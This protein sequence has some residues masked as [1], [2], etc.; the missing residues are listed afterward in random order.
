MVDQT[1]IALI[2]T[3][4]VMLALLGILPQGTFSNDEE[5]LTQTFYIRHEPGLEAG[6][7]S[8]S[9][10]AGMPGIYEIKTG[11]ALWYVSLAAMIA[12]VVLEG[13]RAAWPLPVARTA[14]AIVGPV[15]GAAALGL[16][17]SGAQAYA[18]AAD[19]MDW[20]PAEA[21]MYA[22]IAA[23]VSAFGAWIVPWVRAR[24]QARATATT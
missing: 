11:V 7:W 12:W 14:A 8:G 5:S 6:S 24:R 3:A 18:N 17:T 9:E 2:L 20:T 16:Y 1:R 4:S 15:A 13:R 22:M 19:H 21:P 10:E 23:L